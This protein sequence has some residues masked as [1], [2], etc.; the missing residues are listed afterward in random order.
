MLKMKKEKE[1]RLREKMKKINLKQSLKLRNLTLSQ[2]SWNK[3]LFYMIKL[4][5]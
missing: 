4:E 1:K 3:S 5:G 2:R